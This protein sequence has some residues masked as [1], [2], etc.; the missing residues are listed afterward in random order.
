MVDHSLYARHNLY[1]TRT[2]IHINLI[3]AI[4]KVIDI[5]LIYFIKLNTFILHTV[6][7]KFESINNIFQD[8]LAKKKYLYTILKKKTKANLLILFLKI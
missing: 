7:D 8:C 3:K 4:C 2:Y 1:L 5:T 6:Q